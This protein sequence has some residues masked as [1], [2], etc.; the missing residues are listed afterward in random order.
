MIRGIPECD[1]TRKP[2]L[3][4]G[5]PK[6]KLH[7]NHNTLGFFPSIAGPRSPDIA[8]ADVDERRKIHDLL[9]EGVE[10]ALKKRGYPA[11]NPV[12]NNII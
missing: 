4:K 1:A 6:M 7:D 2:R 5:I 8:S 11:L 3:L 12:H 10:L 9:M